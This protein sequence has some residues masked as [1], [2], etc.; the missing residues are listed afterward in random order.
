MK[1]SLH[2]DEEISTSDVIERYEN[3]LKPPKDRWL[4]RGLTLS[5]EMK[6]LLIHDPH[7]GL[8]S[9][10]MVV[11]AGEFSRTFPTV[12]SSRPHD[13]VKSPKEICRKLSSMNLSLA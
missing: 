5:N 13:K 3:I 11:G 6:V 1:F 8:S 2:S 9:V 7:P 12:E 10:S 4:Y